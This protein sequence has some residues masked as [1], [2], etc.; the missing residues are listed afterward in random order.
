[1]DFRGLLLKERGRLYRKGE[2]EREGNGGDE[3][4]ESR[5]PLQWDE[6]LKEREME[7]RE[8]RQKGEQRKKEGRKERSLSYQQKIVPAPVR[9]CSISRCG[10]FSRC[11]RRRRVATRPQSNRSTARICRKMCEHS[12]K[13]TEHMRTPTSVRA[14]KTP[15]SALSFSKIVHTYKNIAVFVEIIVITNSVVKR[16][17]P[18]AG[19][20]V[21]HIN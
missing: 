18:V 20:G 13:L 12:R 14:L 2:R 10:G 6:D 3:W 15:N 16:L 11:P 8:R 1:M 5:G 21:G 19:F 7:M 9:Q 17:F 4:E